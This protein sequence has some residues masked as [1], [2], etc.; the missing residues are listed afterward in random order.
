MRSTLVLL[1]IVVVVAGLAGCRPADTK[2]AAPPASVAAPPAPSEPPAATGAPLGSIKVGDKA[3]CSACAAEGGEHG[4]E[5]VKATL[6]YQGKTYAFC[7]EAEKAQF[8]SERTGGAKGG[9]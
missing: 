4:L 8:I 1:S 3:V 2:D 9:E 5:E 7:S 6:D